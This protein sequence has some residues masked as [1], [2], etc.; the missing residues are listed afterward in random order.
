MLDMNPM[1]TVARRALLP[2]ALTQSVPAAFAETP[3]VTRTSRQWATVSSRFGVH[4]AV[5]QNVSFCA[6][7]GRSKV[8]QQ[9]RHT[10][11]EKKGKR[12]LL[13]STALRPSER[14]Y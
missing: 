11:W 8:R 4:A 10:R 6:F 14:V 1:R 5:Q 3:D 2:S 12:E 7:F 13:A 9:K